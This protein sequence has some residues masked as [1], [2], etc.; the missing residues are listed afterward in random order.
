MERGVKWRWARRNVNV[1]PCAD[2]SRAR[3]QH[4]SSSSEDNM[5]LIVTLKVGHLETFP[6]HFEYFWAA[7]IMESLLTSCRSTVLVECSLSASNF[8]SLRPGISQERPQKI[9]AGLLALFL[10]FLRPMVGRCSTLGCTKIQ[11]PALW[12]SCGTLRLRQPLR[13][14]NYAHFLNVKNKIPLFS[15]MLWTERSCVFVWKCPTWTSAAPAGVEVSLVNLK[16]R[17]EISGF[18]TSDG[19]GR[20]ERPHQDASPPREPGGGTPQTLVP[21]QLWPPLQSSLGPLFLFRPLHTVTSR[22]FCYRDRLR[23]THYQRCPITH[24][25]CSFHSLNHRSFSSVSSVLFFACISLFLLLTETETE[26]DIL[27]Y[28]WNSGGGLRHYLSPTFLPQTAEQPFTP[29]LR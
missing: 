7:T 14:L 3:C 25:C 24:V 23:Q 19:G 13:I 29:G 11:K 2:V 18:L 1:V 20:H 21:P 26:V 9:Q 6:V 8:I 22:L 16:S 10:S 15:V 12:S 5:F 28:K 4:R 27:L 17:T